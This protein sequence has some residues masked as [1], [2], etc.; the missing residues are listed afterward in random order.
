[1]VH[2]CPSLGFR[3]RPATV[4]ATLATKATMEEW[5]MAYPMYFVVLALICYGVAY[6]AYGKWYDRK[7]WQP[8]AKRTT[9]AHMYTDGVEYFP[10]SKAV[11]WGY[12]FKSVAALGP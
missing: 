6:F 11:L 1:Q 7:V 5:S 8:D 4:G 3:S 2:R 12:Q 9:P 10:V